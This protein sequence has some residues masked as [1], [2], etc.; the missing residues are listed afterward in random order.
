[1]KTIKYL[2]DVKKTVTGISYG[3]V[4][5]LLQIIH[6]DLESQDDSHATSP[7]EFHGGHATVSGPRE[8]VAVAYDAEYLRRMIYWYSEGVPDEEKLAMIHDI[9]VVLE[10][11]HKEKVLHDPEMPKTPYIWPKYF[12]PASDFMAEHEEPSKNFDDYRMKE[13]LDDTY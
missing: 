12:R 6:S 9:N 3:Y 7:S 13:N 10:K 8:Y 1:M 5:L 11:L 4:S 2:M